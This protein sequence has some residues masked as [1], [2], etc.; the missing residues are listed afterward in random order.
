[1]QGGALNLSQPLAAPKQLNLKSLAMQA[2]PKFSGWPTQ[3]K[4]DSSG[5]LCIGLNLSLTRFLSDW[6]KIRLWNRIFGAN[7]R[8]NDRNDE[9]R[10]RWKSFEELKW[11]R[12]LSGF[13]SNILLLL[14]SFPYSAV[15]GFP[16]TQSG[17]IFSLFPSFSRFIVSIVDLGET[18]KIRRASAICWGDHCLS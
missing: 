2:G 11:C 6:P 4:T 9:T 16:S 15:W 18:F 17:V 7:D 5:C 10:K 14:Q 8:I 13:F 12:L 1:M 3:Q